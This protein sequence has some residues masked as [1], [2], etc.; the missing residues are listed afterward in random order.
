MKKKNRL[1]VAV[2]LTDARGDGEGRAALLA[3]RS[4]TAGRR[5]S[6]KM[7]CTMFNGGVKELGMIG[8]SAVLCV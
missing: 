3:G 1:A 6:E 8:R 2:Q 4:K 5:S 7:R